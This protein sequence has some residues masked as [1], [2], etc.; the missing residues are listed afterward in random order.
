MCHCWH[1]H[2]THKLPF[3]HPHLKLQ[4]GN[5]PFALCLLSNPRQCILHTSCG[6][7]LWKECESEQ[8]EQWSPQC[9]VCRESVSPAG[10]VM[11]WLGTRVVVVLSGA[12][13]PSVPKRV[14]EEAVPASD[15]CS[16]GIQELMGILGQNELCGARDVEW[17]EVHFLC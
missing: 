4:V 16:S 7:V 1:G 3:Q 8:K 15:R 11:T 10:F 13:H 14:S 12:N 9:G 17:D 2:G 5:S 6:E